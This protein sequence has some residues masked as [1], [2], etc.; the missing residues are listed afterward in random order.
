[1]EA[2][3]QQDNVYLLMNGRWTLYEFFKT[4]L[5]FQINEGTD[6]DLAFNEAIN[7]STISTLVADPLFSDKHIENFD[8]VFKWKKEIVLRAL[9]AA[10]SLLN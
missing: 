5:E 10:S 2:D 4:N 3:I 8:M 7:L 1:M 6:Y 9:T